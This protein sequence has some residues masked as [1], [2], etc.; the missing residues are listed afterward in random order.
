MNA[1]RNKKQEPRTITQGE[2]KLKSTGA[3]VRKG[4]LV[5]VSSNLFGISFVINRERTVIGRGEQCDLHLDDP[6]VSREHCAITVDGECNFFLE[7]LDSKNRT[8]LNKKPVKKKRQMFYGDRLI[9]GST[10]LRFFLE[11][12]M[13]V[14]GHPAD[15]DTKRNGCDRRDRGSGNSF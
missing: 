14:K 6:L 4:V 10:I 2:M 9:V 12:K 5:V 13:R 8:Y 15:S 7:D 1:R 11:E 3:L